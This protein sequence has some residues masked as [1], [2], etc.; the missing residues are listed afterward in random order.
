[1]D[2]PLIDCEKVKYTEGSAFAAGAFTITV[3]GCSNALLLIVAQLVNCYVEATGPPMHSVMMMA[4]LC[5]NQ[6][7]SL[8]TQQV[9][10]QSFC[11]MQD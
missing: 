8:E 1:M 6:E 5:S 3:P 10:S 11:L 4:G 9:E 7:D 2:D